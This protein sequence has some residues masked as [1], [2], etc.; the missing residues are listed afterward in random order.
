M[1][2]RSGKQ[3]FRSP[4]ALPVCRNCGAELTTHRERREEF[5]TS[6]RCRPAC[7][8]R[9]AKRA[10][11][12]EQLA[13]QDRDAHALDILAALKDNLRLSP[14]LPDEA[15]LMIIP[16][17]TRK[18]V[19]QPAERIAEFRDHLNQVMEQAQAHVENADEHESIQI[20]HE[21]R[22][23]RAQTSLPVINACTTCGGSCCL[24]AAGHAF[25][26]RDF[27][28]WRLLNE[29]DT[30]VQEK[31]EDYMRRIPEQA[32]EN[33][34]VYHGAKGCVLPREIRSSTCNDF[35]CTG[36]VD[37]VRRDR[38]RNASISIA[39]VDSRG[40]QR[41]GIAGDGVERIEIT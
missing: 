11:E 34:C 33:S 35:L 5:C 18:I 32:Y 36:I 2:S 22:A 27:F 38:G 1:N 30:A 20:T 10:A 14:Q 4:S 19:K 3:P 12:F 16:E 13:K 41:I 24:Q 8:A 25:L 17:N 31:I 9:L 7:V 40:I 37:G 23:V 26:N 21:D 6:L 15:I 39:V 29:P 28:A